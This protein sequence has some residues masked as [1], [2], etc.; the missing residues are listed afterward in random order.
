ME[1]KEDN[2]ILKAYNMLLLF[3]GSMIM[4]EPTKECVVD[5]W[6]NGLL[7]QLPV[8]SSNPRFISAASQLKESVENISLCVDE[9]Q[10]DYRRLFPLNS[11]SLVPVRES[12][13]TGNGEGK[14]LRED[15][16]EFYN[17]YGWSSKLRSKEND[18]HLSI[19][20]LFLT[21][22]IEKYLDLDDEPCR[23][24]MAREIRRFISKHLLSWIPDWNEKV[25]ENATTLCYKGIGT[26]IYA[27]IE[28]INNVLA[29]KEKASV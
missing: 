14:G 4:Y 16:T 23:R 29:S 27:C 12:L 28:D 25:Q 24:E 2:S 20:I 7:K 8:K 6:K 13:Y 1:N 9:L 5:F 17:S 18:D 26:L 22:M 3:A 15:V 10:N 19:E 11:H 21:R